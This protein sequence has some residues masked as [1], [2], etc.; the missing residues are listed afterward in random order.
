MVVAS[1]RRE[2]GSVGVVQAPGD[3]GT[4]LSVSQG[5]LRGS[6]VSATSDE[7]GADGHTNF[8]GLCENG[9]AINVDFVA[10]QYGTIEVLLQSDLRLESGGVG[11][12]SVFSRDD[13]DRSIKRVSLGLQDFSSGR[14]ANFDPCLCLLQYGFG[15]LE[16]VV[17]E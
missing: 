2:E 10:C 15:S 11:V 8:D 12:D 1:C 4:D 16:L 9:W 13:V 3:S 17:S 7:V 5:L 6:D 14:V